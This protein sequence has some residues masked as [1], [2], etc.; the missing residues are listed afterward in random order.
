MSNN[1][2][3]GRVPLNLRVDE[4]KVEKAIARDYTSYRSGITHKP[5]YRSQYTDPRLSPRNTGCT[6]L[7]RYPNGR[8][9]FEYVAQEIISLYNK[10]RDH[11]HVTEFE[12]AVL[13]LVLPQQFE[14]LIDPKIAQTMTKLTKDERMVLAMMVDRHVREELNWNAG[15]GGGSVRGRGQ[16]R[17]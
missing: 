5:E 1:P 4:D 13:C 6:I 12:K 10:V 16:T 7:R 15:F 3:A 17:S 8:L 14:S 11:G 9:C 2:Y